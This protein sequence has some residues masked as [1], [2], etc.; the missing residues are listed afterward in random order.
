MPQTSRFEL[1]PDWVYG[2]IGRFECVKPLL[3]D[4]DHDPEGPAAGRVN[5]ILKGRPV[6]ELDFREKAMLEEAAESLAESVNSPPARAFASRAVR[7]VPKAFPKDA[8]SGRGGLRVGKRA[9]RAAAVEYQAVLAALVECWF[10]RVTSPPF[11]FPEP[12]RGWRMLLFALL[13]FRRARVTARPVTRDVLQAA[14]GAIGREDGAFPE[15]LPG[16]AAAMIEQLAFASRMR[17]ALEDVLPSSRAAAAAALARA[18]EAAP[19]QAAAGRLGNDPAAR[20]GIQGFLEE[21]ALVREA[22][23]AYGAAI[24]RYRETLRGVEGLEKFPVPG[25]A[26][27]LELDDEGFASAL[28]GLAAGWRACADSLYT[29][30]LTALDPLLMARQVVADLRAR[31]EAEGPRRDAAVLKEIEGSLKAVQDCDPAWEEKVPLVPLLIRFLR[32]GK[33]AVDPEL[34]P[35]EDELSAGFFRKFH[36]GGFDDLFAGR[37]SASLVFPGQETEGGAAGSLRYRPLADEQE[38]GEEQE[39]EGEEQGERLYWNKWEDRKEQEEEREEQEREELD[40]QE[41]EEQDD[42]EHQDDLKER[43]GQEGQGGPGG[44]RGPSREAS[45]ED[46]RNGRG[47]EKGGSPVGLDE[48]GIAH[49]GGGSNAAAAGRAEVEGQADGGGE[50]REEYGRPGEPREAG[51]SPPVAAAEPRTDPFRAFRALS[52][53][54]LAELITGKFGDILGDAASRGVGDHGPVC[55]AD[56]SDLGEEAAPPLAALSGRPGSGGDGDRS[57]DEEAEA[58]RE[59]LRLRDLRLHLA[60][61]CRR[62]AGLGD[63]RPLYWLA[64]A[65]PAGVFP[66][67]FARLLHLGL[68][69]RPRPLAVKEAFFRS[70]EACLPLWEPEGGRAAGDPETAA[71]LYAGILRAAASSPEP[72]LGPVLASLA[73]RLPERLRGGLVGE[74]EA[75]VLRSDAEG[76]LRALRRMAEARDRDRRLA[77]LEGKTR[78]F[79]EDMP[80]RSTSYVPA[81]TLWKNLIGPGG[82]LREFLERCR[83]GG[84]DIAALSREAEGLRDVGN[85]RELVD[86]RDNRTRNQ[87]PINSKAFASLVTYFSLTADLARDWLEFHGVTEAG[88]GGDWFVRSLTEVFREAGRVLAALPSPPPAH[89]GDGNG[90]GGDGN[91]RGGNGNGRGRG[92]DGSGWGGGGEGESGGGGS[93]DPEGDCGSIADGLRLLRSELQALST[94]SFLDDWDDERVSASGREGFFAEDVDSDLASWLILC[95]GATSAGGGPSGPLPGVLRALARGGRDPEEECSEF[96]ARISEGE[97][98]IPSHYLEAVGAAR[99]R[100]PA[101]AEGRTLAEHLDDAARRFFEETEALLEEAA[102]RARNMTVSGSLDASAAEEYA[103]DAGEALESLRAA[104]GEGDMRS[105]AIE[106]EVA[107]WIRS[108]AESRLAELRSR[109]ENRLK[110]LRKAGF[111]LP[112]AL[113]RQ[114]GDMLDEGETDAAADLV[115]EWTARALRK[116]P[117][118]PLPEEGSRSPVRDF[119]RALPSLRVA[120]DPFAAARQARDAGKAARG[121]GRASQVEG[122]WGE[123]MAARDSAEREDAARAALEKLLK[124]LGFEVGKSFRAS[125]GAEGGGAFPWRE[126]CCGVSCAPPLPAWGPGPRGEIS[127]LVWW[128]GAA[129]P[130]HL[131]E[132][133]ESCPPPPGAVPLAVAL[134]P[135]APGFWGALWGWAREAGRDLVVLDTCLAAFIA[136]RAPAVKSERIEA[137]FSAGGIYGA[138]R[139]FGPG[140]ARTGF[141]GQEDIIRLLSGLKGLW[142]IQGAAGVGK[143]ALLR[144]FLD[145]PSVH[146]PTDGN[147]ACLLDAEE[148]LAGDPGP[149]GH[150]AFL[151]F[152]W[153][154]AAAGAGGKPAGEGP[155]GTPGPLARLLD[156]A[157]GEMGL[158]GWDPAAAH[159]DRVRKLFEHRGQKGWPSQATVMIDRADGL[160]AR[161]VRDPE[162]LAILGD[163]ADDQTG[164]LRLVLAGRR[165]SWRLER[166][167]LSPLAW[168]TLPTRMPVPDPAALHAMLTRPLAD[169]GFFFAGR[170]LAYRVLARA[171]WNPAALAVAAAR[172]LEEAVMDILPDSPPPFEISERAVYRAFADPETEARL[173]DIAL[174]PLGRDPRLRAVALAVSYMEQVGE[175]PYPGAGAPFPALLRNLRDFWPDAFRDTGLEELRHLCLELEGAGVLAPDPRGKRFR[176]ASQARLLGDPDRV[177]D[178]L[179]VLKDT[180]APPDS[181]RLSCRRILPPA[182]PGIRDGGDLAGAGGPGGR[183]AGR[184][185]SALPVPSPFT[186]LQEMYLFMWGYDEMPVAAEPAGGAGRAAAALAGLCRL[187]NGPGSPR[188]IFAGAADGVPPGAR[189][190]WGVREAEIADPPPWIRMHLFTDFPERLGRAGRERAAALSQAVRK[191]ALRPFNGGALTSLCGAVQILTGFPEKARNRALYP[192][193]WTRGAVEGW[194]ISCGL[195]AGAAAGIMER[196]GGWDSL[197]MAEVH[198]LA[199]LACPALPPEE[200]PNAAPRELR[201]IILATRRLCPITLH[202]LEDLARPGPD[203]P[204]LPETDG[205]FDDGTGEPRQRFTYLDVFRLLIGLT[206]LVPAGDRDGETLWAVDSRFS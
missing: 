16:D 75:L 70:L 18:G 72:G 159:R 121:A 31:L 125:P 149:A 177:L 54:E 141:V 82:E 191:R 34:L 131:I 43:D 100:R 85:V 37:P 90:R 192:E 73:E 181:S 137:L 139:P 2:V 184:G 41:R 201:D 29:G 120:D 109:T 111:P 161:I 132:A 126:Y 65:S 94:M 87:E 170:G 180:P 76:A 23:K 81:N 71:L 66:A 91:G 188:C 148:E 59:A 166:H 52:V 194:L 80:K 195:D 105:A 67:E 9:L 60:A 38:E 51:A 144:H 77:G 128:G 24:S 93:A 127:A 79:F 130:G 167:T 157:A 156:R 190:V 189:D 53:P 129:G 158:P 154:E 122:H 1:I 88:E 164:A 5:D 199:G 162:D 155:A 153:A 138:F 48:A 183:A 62:L 58:R 15:G 145:D 25:L 89:G 13:E 136:A 26:E 172:I 147:Y 178:E 97:A 102:E 12:L 92:G 10:E 3:D 84:G 176:A 174:E 35:L 39:E 118:Q 47:A 175:L 78:K 98:L 99:S 206:V 61:L 8:L 112:P 21:A 86:R 146:K 152:P 110:Q 42:Q 28:S 36:A 133:L 45:G 117:Q 197:V 165:I 205:L 46:G 114:V 119:F 103:R 74:L 20:R 108:G 33:G 56:Y 11:V 123:L 49:G 179:S 203:G 134:A 204:P 198:A 143:T 135:L 19:P 107:R 160:M 124:W 202:E 140:A 187:V 115:T 96:L 169:M 27:A 185:P 200:Y 106:A 68:H 171:F 6:S 104:A 168:L 163:I 150:S 83:R 142:R 55:F 4:L 196:T 113:V 63:T 57:A 101:G 50:G 151:E 32:S 64:A 30:A 17:K 186:F 40:G 116:L 22:W 69:F 182:V 44:W 193:R 95:P 14:V 7:L 173:R